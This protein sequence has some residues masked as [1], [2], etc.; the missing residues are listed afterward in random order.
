MAAVAVAVPDLEINQILRRRVPTS[1]VD[2]RAIGESVAGSPDE[3]ARGAWG[4]GGRARA[5]TAVHLD[6]C[7]I[8]CNRFARRWSK[9]RSLRFP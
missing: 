1:S 2:V 4:E 7:N 9:M 3:H 8:A 5:M 6:A